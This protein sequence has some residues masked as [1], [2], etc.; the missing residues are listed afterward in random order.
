MTDRVNTRCLG[1]VVLLITAVI[2]GMAFA[3]QRA[4]MEWIEPATFQ[5]VR[6]A[7]ASLFVWL[8]SFAM[9]RR[10]GR[11]AEGESPEARRQMRTET[12]RG[13]VCCGCFLA[14][15]NYFQQFGLVYTTAGKA[16]FITALYI[17]L[18]PLVSFLL[19]RR[20]VSRRILLAVLVGVIGLYLLCVTDSFRLTRGDELVCL[21]ALLFCGH[22]LSCNQFAG[23]GDA[24]RMSA[25]QLMTAA[26]ISAVIA[27]L[28]ET[29]TWDKIISAA[30]PILYCGIVSAGIGYTCQMVGQKYTE[31]AVASL[32][33]SLE[34]VFAVIGGAL[35]L[36]ER[37]TTRELLGCAV[38]FTAILLVQ[39]PV[40]Y[41]RPGRAAQ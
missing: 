40:P 28:T 3:F 5:A 26:I 2:W 16:G 4:G 9:N 36:G 41:H 10:K 14:A 20:R 32:L 39:V 7:L 21:S 19:F 25:V 37:M 31:P 29:P 15:A 18:V 33:M 30:V 6:L 35:L 24:V 1:T 8:I 34:S 13:G 12:L 11:S 27:L 22:I 38:M 23:R 17:I